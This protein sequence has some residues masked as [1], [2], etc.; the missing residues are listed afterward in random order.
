[1]P[2]PR[3]NGP[4]LPWNC[5]NLVDPYLCYGWVADK[6]GRK[7]SLIFYTLCAAGLIPLYAQRARVN[8]PGPGR[9]RRILWNRFLTGSGIIG[10]ELFPT[11]VR[12]LS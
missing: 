1:M 11:R 4:K 2:A 12:A 9:V 5:F 6:L 8:H 10:S 3:R 7:R